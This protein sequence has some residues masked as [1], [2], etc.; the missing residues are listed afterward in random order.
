MKKVLVI[1]ANGFVGPYL[2]NNLIEHGYDVFG[3]KLASEKILF[4]GKWFDIDILDKDSIKNVIEIIKPDFIVHLAALSSVKLSWDKPDLTFQI[5]VIGIINIFETLKNLKLKPRILLVGSS[6]EYGQINKSTVREDHKVNPLN[7]YALS[8]VTQEKIGK[9]YKDN[10]GFDVIFA[11][12]FNH[13]GPGQSTQFVVSDFANQIANIEKENNNNNEIHVGN[14]KAKRDFSDVRDIVNAYRLLLEKGVNG[15]IYNVGSGKSISIEEILNCL[16]SFSNKKI[17]IKVDENKFRP[18]DTPEIKADISKLIND[19]GYTI[20]FDIK[21]TLF[22]V[23]Q[24]F[25]NNN[26]EK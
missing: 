1:G 21:Q 2:C 16:I 12:S 19:T 25:R 26:Y 11:R 13:I 18:I 23:L 4:N 10:Y 3:T 5:N 24:Y 22:N 17:N 14:L 8:K 6:E 7:F 15:E 9:I 20:Q